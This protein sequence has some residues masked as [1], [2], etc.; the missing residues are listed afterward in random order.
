MNKRKPL[1]FNAEIH[2]A[3]KLA[4]ARR[5]EKMAPVLEEYMKRY[6]NGD[7]IRARAILDIINCSTPTNE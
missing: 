7:R 5:G 2:E 3:F 4:T 1:T 6:V